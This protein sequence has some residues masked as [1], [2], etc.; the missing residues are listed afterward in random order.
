MADARLTRC[1]GE[2]DKK[3][4]YCHTELPTAALSSSVLSCLG[5][6]GGLLLVSRAVIYV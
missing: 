5:G 2:K 1:R 6:H 4:N 3:Q